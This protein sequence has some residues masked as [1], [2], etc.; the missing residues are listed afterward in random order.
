[1]RK[2]NKWNNKYI[3]WAFKESQERDYLSLLKIKTVKEQMWASNSYFVCYSK[4]GVKEY[5]ERKKP[6]YSIV[7]EFTGEIY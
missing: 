3:V 7:K 2:S 1:M 4:E 5:L 6:K